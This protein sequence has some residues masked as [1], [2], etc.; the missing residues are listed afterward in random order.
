MGLTAIRRCDISAAHDTLATLRNERCGL[1]SAT[2]DVKWRD[3]MDAQHCTTQ[4][5]GG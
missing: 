2:V 4:I 3:S 5:L 1:T